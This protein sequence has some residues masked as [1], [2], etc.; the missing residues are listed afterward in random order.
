EKTLLIEGA[1]PG[2]RVR[3]EIAQAAR[4]MRGKTLEV[5]RSSSDR[6]TPPC[7]HA[8]RCGGCDLMHASMALQRRTRELAVV[9]QLRAVYRDRLPEPR[10]HTP[11]P[12]LAYRSRARL[13]VHARAGAT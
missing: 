1:L 6:V 9:E 4:L 13:V 2:E 7:E 10:L 5:V 11:R 12:P 8:T 3:A